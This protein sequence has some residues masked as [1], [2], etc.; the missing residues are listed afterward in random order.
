M[1]PAIEFGDIRAA[2]N[3][4]TAWWSTKE[5]S[6]TPPPEDSAQR[7]VVILNRQQSLSTVD[8]PVV[9]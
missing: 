4:V 6:C 8:P 9:V 5:I 1:T 7:P 2:A 3:L